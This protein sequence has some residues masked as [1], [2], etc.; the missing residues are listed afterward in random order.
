MAHIH[1]VSSSRGKSVTVIAG[2]VVVGATVLIEIQQW[3]SWMSKAA[4]GRGL[5]W[6]SRAL[7][8]PRSAAGGLRGRGFRLR[9]PASLA[10][11][12]LRPL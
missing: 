10:Q 7:E 12:L 2:S 8:Q 5:A 1:A 4:L 6:E 11:L 3:R 9:H